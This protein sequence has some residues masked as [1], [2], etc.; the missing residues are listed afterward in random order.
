VGKTPFFSTMGWGKVGKL[1]VY[2]S[3][4][5]SRILTSVIRVCGMITWHFDVLTFTNNCKYHDW[6][7]CNQYSG[8]AVCWKMGNEFSMRREMFLLVTV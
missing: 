4:N 1:V 5:L 7:Q 8:S 2:A 6:L 3:C